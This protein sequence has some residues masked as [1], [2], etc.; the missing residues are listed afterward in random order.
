MKSCSDCDRRF[1]VMQDELKYMP[2]NDVLD[3]VD[4]QM[5]PKRLAGKRDSKG[6]I[7]CL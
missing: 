4:V 5:I 3:L 6:N 2:D 1:T 7:E